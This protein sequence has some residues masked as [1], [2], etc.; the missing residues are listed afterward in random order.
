MLIYTVSRQPESRGPEEAFPTVFP[1]RKRMMKKEVIF[2]L[3]LLFFF[4]LAGKEQLQAR[5]REIDRLTAL[6]AEKEN[7]LRK[8]R[9]WLSNLNADARVIS[10]SDRE[11]RLMHG[12]KILSDASGSMVLKSL[13]L[14]ELLRSK[15]SMLPLASADRVRLTMALEELERSAARVNSIADAAAAPEGTH[16]T[17]VRVMNI[18]YD[19]NMAVISAGALHGVFPGMT[20]TTADGNHRLRVLETRPMLSGVLPVA[21]DLNKLTP[22]TAVRLEILRKSPERK[23]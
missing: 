6:L 16:L 9:I 5:Q 1:E 2:F 17:N 10:V 15:L 19:L 11:Q 13:E 12:L 3:L 20:F 14:T 7:E 21:G 4:P 23:R 18:N 8:L 22:G